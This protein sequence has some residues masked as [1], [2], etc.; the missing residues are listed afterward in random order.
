MKG[1][2]IFLKAVLFGSVMTC[3]AQS[4]QTSTSLNQVDNEAALS[5]SFANGGIGFGLIYKRQVA[6]NRY[7]RLSL[8][9]IHIMRRAS[10]PVHSGQFRSY[11]E[12]VS[13]NLELGVEWRFKVHSKVLLFTGVDAVLGATHYASRIDNPALPEN[14]QIDQ[15]FTLRTG[16]ALNSGVLVNVHEVIR[17]GLNISPGILYSWSPWEYEDA[18]AITRKGNEHRISTTL[19]SGSV[20]ALVVF[21]WGSAGRR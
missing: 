13:A 10:V 18:N 7:F 21:H 19:S 20:Q 2:A 17:V 8:A 6:E 12:N 9:D 14:Q 1:V 16:V 11:G 15:D 5:L 4:D 3:S